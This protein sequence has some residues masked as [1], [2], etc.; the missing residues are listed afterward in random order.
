L[1][2]KADA[3][4]VDPDVTYV[5]TRSENDYRV[6]LKA[7]GF[8][9]TS[10]EVQLDWLGYNERAETREVQHT[11]TRVELGRYF[12]NK[13]RFFTKKGKQYLEVKGWDTHSYPMKKQRFVFL[14]EPN[15]DAG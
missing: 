1:S 12:L 14:V 15:D 6:I 3:I 10:T 11:E 5:V 8:E 4:I 2:H 13:A 9:H 7:T